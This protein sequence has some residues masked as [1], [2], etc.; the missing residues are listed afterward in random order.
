MF[1]FQNIL[2][3]FCLGLALCESAFVDTLHKCDY[4]DRECLMKVIQNTLAS[5]ADTGIPE[6]DIPPIDPLHLQNI[7]LNLLNVI[8]LMILEGTVKGLKNCEVKDLKLNME[9]GHFT[10]KVVCDVT[11]KGKYDITGSS[12]ALKD[13]VGGSSVRGSGNAKIKID[14]V[15]MKFDYTFDVVRRPDGE[16]YIECKKELA[17]YDF[18]LLG[19]SKL[20]LDKLY[21]GDVESS[22]ILS[23]Y[24]NDNAKTLWKTFGRSVIDSIAD[25]A[26]EFIHN[27]FGRVPAKHY[28]S[29]DLSTFIK[30]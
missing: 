18:D 22:Q 9:K 11:A 3:F 28:L 16:V 12:P 30:P 21:V 20:Q 7:K 19:G 27:F 8:D 6:Y 23:N 25:I 26:Y 4:K 10:M 14:K 1:R 24:Y 13:L 29:G 2:A 17:K 5:I 15:M